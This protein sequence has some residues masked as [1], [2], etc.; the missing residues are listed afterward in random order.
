MGF[1]APVSSLIA[2]GLPIFFNT[3]HQGMP[4]KLTLIGILCAII[5][6]WY[7]SLGRPGGNLQ[8]RNVTKHIVAG[9]GFGL[10]FF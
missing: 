4:N 3:Y 8:I 1:V 6:I 10:I 5:G 7:L 9:I 2:S